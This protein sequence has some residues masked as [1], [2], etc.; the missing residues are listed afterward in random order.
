MG[1]LYVLQGNM[2]NYREILISLAWRI[3]VSL[4]FFV[5]GVSGALSVISPLFIVVGG[6]IVGPPFARLVAEPA[7]NLFYPG[8]RFSRPQPAYSIPQ[9]K[10][11]KGLYEEA[12]AEFEAIADEYPAE[13]RPYIEM[14][15]ISIVNLKDPDRADEIFQRGISV[16][17]KEADKEVLAKTYS[18][19]R[20]LLNAKPSN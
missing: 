2:S 14:I 6:I 18:V 16:L 7:G 19:I 4:P 5:I 10:R 20:T 3:P 12:I 13:V 1:G 15:D 11:A 8:R 17:K 9:S